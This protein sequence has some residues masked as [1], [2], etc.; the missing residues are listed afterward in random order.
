MTARNLPVT[1]YVHLVMLPE[2]AGLYGAWLDEA[3]AH[4]HARK[5]GGV[6]AAVPISG[7]Y[8][9]RQP[10]AGKVPCGHPDKWCGLLGGSA[11]C[12]GCKS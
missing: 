5:I 3:V 11:S 7:D 12:G 8:R 1:S 4:E 9:A 6:V 2:R 10:E